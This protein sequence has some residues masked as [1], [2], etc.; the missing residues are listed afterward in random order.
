MAVRLAIDGDNGPVKKFR[1]KFLLY[2][3]K[4]KTMLRNKDC[5]ETQR[6]AYNTKM[7]DT[8]NKNTRI[9]MEN[10]IQ[11]NQGQTMKKIL[12]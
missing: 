1:P 12:V 10:P 8:Q 9:Y 7:L 11:E 4:K 3:K 6:K 5:Y 2:P